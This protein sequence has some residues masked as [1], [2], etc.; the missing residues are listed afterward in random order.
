MKGEGM[1]AAA[2]AGGGDDGG[3]SSTATPAALLKSTDCRVEGGGF[4]RPS[5]SMSMTTTCD[6]RKTGENGKK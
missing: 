3:V 4:I 1:A 6:L 5:T 2:A